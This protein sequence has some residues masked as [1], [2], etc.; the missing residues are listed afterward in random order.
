MAGCSVDSMAER[1]AASSVEYSAV[2]SVGHWVENLVE[3][4]VACLVAL[5][6][7]SWAAHLAAQMVDS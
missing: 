2:S 7:D 1:L 5:K 3:T 4:T 6:V